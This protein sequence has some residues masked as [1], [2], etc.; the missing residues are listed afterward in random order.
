MAALSPAESH[1]RRRAAS[2]AILLTSGQLTLEQLAAV[3]RQEIGLA[4]TA[5][6]LAGTGGQRS[7]ELDA[8]LRTAI[9]REYTELDRLTRLLQQ[10]PDMPAGDVQRR[11]EAFADSLDEAQMEGERLTQQPVSPLIPLSIGGALGA[12]LER[13]TRPAGRTMLPRIDRGQIASL[14]GNLRADMDALSDA[15]SNGELTSSD[16][17]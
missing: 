15:M 1:L 13:I 3:M 5:A 8:A 12:L 4:L 7:P 6:F 2:L 10:R 9:Q 11:L 16:W 17:F 14:T